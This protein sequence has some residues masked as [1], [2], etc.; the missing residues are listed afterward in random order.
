MGFKIVKVKI[1]TI[2]RHIW[3]KLLK[4]INIIVKDKGSLSKFIRFC[5]FDFFL[6]SKTVF[7]LCWSITWLLYRLKPLRSEPS[8]KFAVL[9]VFEPIWYL[10]SFFPEIFILVI[11]GFHDIVDFMDSWSELIKVSNHIR[12]YSLKLSH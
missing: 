10:N 3:C 4:N 11:C 6:I 8:N 7:F 2:S 5:H 1:N 9:I 12:K